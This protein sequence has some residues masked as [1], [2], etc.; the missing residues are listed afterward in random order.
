MTATYNATDNTL[1][2]RP[3]KP[4]PRELDY[5]STSVYTGEPSFDDEGLAKAIAEYREHLDNLRTIPCSP[6]CRGLWKP[7]QELEEGKDYELRMHYHAP[8]DRELTAFPL[9]VRSEQNEDELW[10]DVLAEA[11]ASIDWQY[12]EL[13]EEELITK[14]KSRYIITKR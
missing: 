12:Q 13:A 8:D 1:K 4:E 6:E 11:E 14:L 3:W 9:S 10:K 5:Y 7:G 2:E